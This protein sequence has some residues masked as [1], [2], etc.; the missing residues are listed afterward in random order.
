MSDISSAPIATNLFG[1]P[2]LL[3]QYLSPHNYTG[4][5]S[6]SGISNS[7]DQSIGVPDGVSVVFH[8]P[9]SGVQNACLQYDPLITPPAGNYHIHAEVICYGDFPANGSDFALN[10]QPLVS[11]AKEHV[12]VDGVFTSL[13]ADFTA[14]GN[15]GGHLEL[16]VPGGGFVRWRRVGIYTAA[17]WQ[18]MQALNPP[19]VWFSG[20]AMATA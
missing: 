5:A 19:V 16:K 9:N 18:A 13:D 17:D 11:I 10:L 1:N 20:G 15:T 7:G 6:P 14:N 8:D 2:N 12:P 4:G 3:A